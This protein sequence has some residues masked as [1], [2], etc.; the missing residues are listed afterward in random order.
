MFRTSLLPYCSSCRE[1]V[2]SYWTSACHCIHDCRMR[3]LDALVSV[4][5]YKVLQERAPIKHNVRVHVER[6]LLSPACR[7]WSLPIDLTSHKSTHH[8][9]ALSCLPGRSRLNSPLLIWRDKIARPHG[10]GSESQPNHPML[11]QRLHAVAVMLRVVIQAAGCSLVGVSPNCCST[12]LLK[13]RLGSAAPPAGPVRWRIRDAPFLAS[14]SIAMWWVNHRHDVLPA[15]ERLDSDPSRSH[16]QY[17]LMRRSQCGGHA[18][19][20][21]PQR[22]RR[23]CQIDLT[24]PV[25]HSRGCEVPAASSNGTMFPS[26]RVMKPIPN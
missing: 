7:M 12:R 6:T 25:T 2:A 23:T 14:Y 19:S 8:E 9:D 11:V 24:S 5:P 16:C 21:L 10:G 18:Q 13:C 20:R 3:Q 4:T 1:Y 22:E 15:M 17:T 26:C